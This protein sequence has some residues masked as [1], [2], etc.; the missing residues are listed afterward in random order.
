MR[1][2]WIQA[3]SLIKTDFG[4][5]VMTYHP[6]DPRPATLN[7][8]YVYTTNITF[9]PWPVDPWPV[10]CWPVIQLTHLTRWP[11]T[12]WPI[13]PMTRELLTLDPIDPFDSLTRDPLTIWPMTRELLARDPVD[14]FDSLTRDPLTHCHLWVWPNLVAITSDIN[15]YSWRMYHTAASVTIWRDVVNLWNWQVRETNT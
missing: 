4:S 1:S 15:A 14:P 9:D 6:R 12:R 13:W 10:N 8:V 3:A 7:G 11:V 2:Q 5:S